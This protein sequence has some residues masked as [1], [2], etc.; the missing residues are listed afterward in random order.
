MRSQ[1]KPQLSKIDTSRFEVLDRFAKPA[2]APKV[3]HESTELTRS[4]VTFFCKKLSSALSEIRESTNPFSLRI[5]LNPSA[6]S[7]KP[8][9]MSSPIAAGR[10]GL[11]CYKLKATLLSRT[12]PAAGTCHS[13]RYHGAARR[14]LRRCHFR[15]RCSSGLRLLARPLVNAW[16]FPRDTSSSAARER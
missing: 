3:A 16:A 10:S 4:S 15:A 9:M 6:Q 13:A 11:S 2:N 14:S 12:T 1:Q 5:T 8:L 7:T